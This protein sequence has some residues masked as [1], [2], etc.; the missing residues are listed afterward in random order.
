[1][2]TEW[3]YSDRASTYDKRADYSKNAIEKLITATRTSPGKYVAD[4]GAGTG[5]LTKLLI[6]YSLKIHA[7]EP[8]DS[9]RM[10]GQKNT[11]DTDVI[12][13][14]G[15]GEETKL[16]DST[17]HAAF[18]GSSFNV[19]NQQK[20]LREVARILTQDGWFACMWNH[21]DIEDPL[22]KEIEGI[23]HKFIPNFDY[24]NRRQDPSSVINQSDFFGVVEKIEEDFTVQM[25]RSDILD[26][27]KSHDT[28]FRQS[29]GRFD[30]VIKAIASIL[31]KDSYEVPY[32]TRIWFSQLKTK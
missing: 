18:F 25:T 16:S 21:R 12:W 27:W 5:K 22:Q 1:M 10:Y 26:A 17:F 32:S 11:A 23:I 15:V 24:G 8:N 29:N 9:M 3:D 4:I 2:K 14:E 7:V 20:T 28:L 13:S 19:L 30:E 6:G 31:I